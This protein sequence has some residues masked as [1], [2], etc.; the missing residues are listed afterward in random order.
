M[1]KVADKLGW[2]TFSILSHSIGGMTSL[3]FTSIA[4]ER[5]C[6]L[7]VIEALG[8]MS[9]DSKGELEMQRKAIAEAPKGKNIQK[10]PS[11]EAA[12][13]RRATM[14]MVGTLPLDA[15][16]VLVQRGTKQTEDGFVWSSDPACLASFREAPREEF[17]QEMLSQIKCPTL[18][19]VADDGLWK[20]MALFG[21][22]LFSTRWYIAVNL[23]Y[24]TSLISHLFTNW[25]TFPKGYFYPGMKAPAFRGIEFVYKI[26]NRRRACKTM[27]IHNL[28]GGGHH[29]H[30]TEPDQ[31]ADAV[32]QWIGGLTA[33]L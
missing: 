5:V 4:P 20:K 29:P 33:K 27:Q 17:M 9:Q 13:E 23:V 30:L 12:A 10:Y 22:R 6:R 3:H 1:Y 18:L 19:V 15:A 24:F 31:V 25:F 11:L 8:W 16:K 28:K 14:N 26:A 32:S 2:D 7:I 21:T